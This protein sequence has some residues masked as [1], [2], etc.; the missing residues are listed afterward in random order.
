MV[1]ESPKGHADPCT[2]CPG[3]KTTVGTGTTS[4]DGCFD[5]ID[6][7]TTYS[8]VSVC[9]A[10]S[11]GKILV[12]GGSACTTP[13]A[14]CSNYTSASVC[15]ACESG[16]IIVNSGA[17]CVDPIPNCKTQSTDSGCSECATEHKLSNDKKNCLRQSSYSNSI[18][19]LFGLTL[20]V[21]LVL[22]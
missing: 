10:C 19:A 13:I 20:G 18:S 1:S 5:Q 2:I 6:S 15:T 11:G 7:C 9:S 17:Q 16:K 12:A 14:Y 21:V 22:F 3:G 8:A 4:V